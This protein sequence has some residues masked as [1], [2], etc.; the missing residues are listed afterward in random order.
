MISTRLA[1]LALVAKLIQVGLAAVQA[2]TPPYHES[3]GLVERRWFR[4]PRLGLHMAK[5][6]PEACRRAAL[7]IS[8]KAAEAACT[9]PPQQ[10]RCPHHRP[11]RAPC[12]SVLR[13]PG[14]HAS[15]RS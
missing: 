8:P 11:Q 13:R 7:P 4:L 3:N 1:L 10:R 12:T 15:R 5:T 2:Q 9:A 6:D 14:R